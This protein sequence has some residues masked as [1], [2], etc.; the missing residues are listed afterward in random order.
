M[1]LYGKPYLTSTGNSPFR[2][3]AVL[4]MPVAPEMHRGPFG[5]IKTHNFMTVAHPVRGCFVHPIPGRGHKRPKWFCTCITSCKRRGA[6]LVQCPGM[7]FTRGPGGHPP[8]CPL[9]V[10]F[11]QNFHERP[12]SGVYVTMHGIFINISAWAQSCPVRS[13]AFGDVHLAYCPHLMSPGHKH[14]QGHRNTHRYHPSTAV[15]QSDYK[16]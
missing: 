9:P 8:T 2:H 13:L 14:P 12:A 16:A 15:L 10:A 5:G 11:T 6:L 4:P 7:H 1:S 3:V